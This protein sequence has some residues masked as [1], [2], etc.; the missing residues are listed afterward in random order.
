HLRN[1]NLGRDY[2]ADVV[3]DIANAWEGAPCPHCGAPMR[4]ERAIEIGNIFKLGT[5]YSSMLGATYL[6]AEGQSH[7]IVMGS[8][9][10]GSGR[11]AQTIVE[12]SHDEEGIIWPVS[13]APYQIALLSLAPATDSET[14]AAAE[15]LL[16]EL[17]SAGLEV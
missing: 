3:A 13:V 5:R 17:E 8:Y 2:Q 10:I 14:T 16:V 4:A 6:D 11:A 15:D 1:V 9:G 7:P 12:Q